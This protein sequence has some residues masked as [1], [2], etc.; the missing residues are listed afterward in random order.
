[1]R[2]DH[3]PLRVLLLAFS[4][5][6]NRHQQEVIDFLVEENRVLQEQI[7][8]R[9]LKLTDCQRRRLAS[10]GK[11]LGRTLLGQVCS[12]VTPDTILRWYRRLIAAKRTYPGAGTGRPGV[13]KVIRKLIIRMASENSTW[14]YCRIQGALKNLGHR[15]SP[16]T[17]RNVLKEHG[18]HPAPDRPTTW[19]NFLRS[20]YG[21]IIQPT[22]NSCAC[23][24]LSRR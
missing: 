15:V 23:N 11:K 19:R 20:P 9:P 2:A 24:E 18:I 5:W 8:N 1:M 22:S 10:K 16:S 4:G 14:G 21:A 13:M 12:I 6:I 3:L 7:G 17:I